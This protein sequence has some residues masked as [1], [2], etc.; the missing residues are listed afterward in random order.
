MPLH[1]LTLGST[2]HFAGLELRIIANGLLGPPSYKLSV[3]VGLGQAGKVQR[4][5]AGEEGKS[6]AC[7]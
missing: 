1:S 6:T 5:G 4:Q 7:A 2:V 3:E